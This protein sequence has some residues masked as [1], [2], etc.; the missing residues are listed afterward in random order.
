L[1][2]FCSPSPQYQCYAAGAAFHASDEHS[3]LCFLSL[4]SYVPLSVIYLFILIFYYAPLLAH[5]HDIAPPSGKRTKLVHE[6][7]AGQ[8]KMRSGGE[9][10]KHAARALSKSLDQHPL[11]RTSSRENA[12]AAAA[13]MDL[14]AKKNR[15]P[16]AA[17]GRLEIPMA[18]GLSPNSTCVAMVNSAGALGIYHLGPLPLHHLERDQEGAPPTFYTPRSF[19]PMR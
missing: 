4:A 17:A 14:E 19:S 2:G 7:A 16:A 11:V 1:R 18:F 9:L 5:T 15:E 3:R 6:T 13:A 10:L 8:E 12:A